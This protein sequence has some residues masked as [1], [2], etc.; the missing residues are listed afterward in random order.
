VIAGVCFEA[1]ELRLVCDHLRGKKLTRESALS[2]CSREASRL[3][4]YSMGAP[5]IE[6]P[7]LTNRAGQLSPES[8]A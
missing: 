2:V 3:R 7:S 6:P 1:M 4:G 8:A 5:G